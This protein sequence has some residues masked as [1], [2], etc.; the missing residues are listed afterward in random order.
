MMAIRLSFKE[1]WSL[2]KL[3]ERV[4]EI[5]EEATERSRQSTQSVKEG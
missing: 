3:R 1:N 5:Y 4:N 2:E